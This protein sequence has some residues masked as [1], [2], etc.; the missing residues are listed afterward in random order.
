MI[1]LT[2][3]LPF[4][5]AVPWLLFRRKT[6]NRIV[7]SARLLVGSTPFRLLRLEGRKRNAP[8]EVETYHGS[9]RFPRALKRHVS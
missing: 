9:K 5:L 3:Q 7:R 1:R 6:P 8:P 2:Q 4:S